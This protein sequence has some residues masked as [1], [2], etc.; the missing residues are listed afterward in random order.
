MSKYFKCSLH[1]AKRSFRRS[2][3]FIF[4]RIGRIAS[5]ES[6]LQLIKGKC[7]PIL[8]CGLEASPLKKLILDHP[9]L[10]STVYS[11]NYLGLTT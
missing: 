5:E 6:V 7:L 8:L 3:N 2:A 1:Y 4:S 11:R 9:T 10:L